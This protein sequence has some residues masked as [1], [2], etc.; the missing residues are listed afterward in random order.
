M[1]LLFG[2]IHG[3]FFYICNCRLDN[4]ICKAN[5]TLPLLDMNQLIVRVSVEKKCTQKITLS[6]LNLFLMF[7]VDNNHT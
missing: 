4:A 3:T 7:D 6:V 1:V 5:Q 2:L